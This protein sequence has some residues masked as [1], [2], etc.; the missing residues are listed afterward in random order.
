[1]RSLTDAFTSHV[2]LRPRLVTWGRCHVTQERI[3]KVPASWK[4]NERVD[5]LPVHSIPNT[6][7]TNVNSVVDES[8][9]DVVARRRKV[10]K[11]EELEETFV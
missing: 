6:A 11:M 10:C 4:D 8:V 1:M 7:S 9:Q 3:P 5:L 2:T